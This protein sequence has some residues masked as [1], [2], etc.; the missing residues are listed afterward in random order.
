MDLKRDIYKHATFFFVQAFQ[1]CH[2]Q[3]KPQVH[4]EVC[5]QQ[6]RAEDRAMQDGGQGG[7][8][9]EGGQLLRQQGRLRLSQRRTSVLSAFSFVFVHC[10]KQGALAMYRHGSK[11]LFIATF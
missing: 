7:V 4:A 8:R 9:S 5:R 2:A 1:E 11:E 10:Q 6:L 3:S